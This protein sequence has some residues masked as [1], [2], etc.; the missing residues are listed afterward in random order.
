M[1]FNKCAGG[2]GAWAQSDG[3]YAAFCA[4]STE[5][6][7]VAHE[8]NHLVSNPFLD[9]G[10]GT[11]GNGAQGE[12]GSLSEA[13]ADFTGESFE[14]Y[15][16]GTNDWLFWVRNGTT[17][18][19][20]AN[21]PAISQAGQPS[22]D[23]Y[24]SPDFYTGT[25][26]DEGEHIN[27]GILNKASYLAV[28]G[29]SFN[30][31]DITGIGFDKVEQIWYRALTTYFQPGETFNEAY[32]DNIR[33]ATDL[34]SPSDVAEVTKALQA[35]E[36]HLSRNVAGDYN[37]NG[38]VD[39][40]D[41]TLW[42]NHL[43]ETFPLTNRDPDALTLAVVDREDFDF[44]KTRYAAAHGGGGP[45]IVPEPTTLALVVVGMI[46]V[47]TLRVPQPRFSARR[48]L[49]ELGVKGNREAARSGGSLRGSR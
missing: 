16:T 44:W 29:G 41:Y 47:G 3:G 23:R 10:Q 15:V 20:L 2:D 48:T 38:Y 18:R 42:R 36:M 49:N 33:A 1:Q 21:P 19:D 9:D 37:L 4:G 39:A 28:E 43:G 13:M 17:T 46:V 22:P 8:F 7:L 6:D 31:Y 40:A 34:Y 35:V 5:N 12:A 24:L 45:A 11:P 25:G 32:V 27:A 26:D 14:R 30:G